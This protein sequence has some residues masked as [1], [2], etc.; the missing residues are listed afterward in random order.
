MTDETAGQG[1]ASS[2]AILSLSSSI[3]AGFPVCASSHKEDDVQTGMTVQNN[4]L[5]ST[6]KSS[7]KKGLRSQLSG[8]SWCWLRTSVCASVAK[9]SE[10]KGGF[11]PSAASAHSHDKISLSQ[12]SDGSHGTLSSALPQGGA[13]PAVPIAAIDPEHPI[14]AISIDAAFATRAAGC[15]S[16][17]KVRRR[18]IVVRA[19]DTQQKVN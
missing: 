3:L 9:T 11:R 19:C 16:T 1:Q 15:P 17:G 4:T 12:H 6:R 10:T 8:P 2:E 14:L 13:E 18:K 5:L 7:C